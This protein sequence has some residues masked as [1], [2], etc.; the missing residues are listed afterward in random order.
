MTIWIVMKHYTGVVDEAHPDP[1]RYEP[2]FYFTGDTARAQALTLSQGL[3]RAMTTWHTLS[4]LAP[5]RQGP[6]HA[7]Q[8]ARAEAVVRAKDPDATSDSRYLV[9]PS[10]PYNGPSDDVTPVIIAM[11]TA[12]AALPNPPQDPFEAIFRLI[13]DAH[14]PDPPP[15]P[16]PPEPEP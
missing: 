2:K 1:R 15:E 13:R 6:D 4:N 10:D 9:E 14:V 12:F 3:N 16:P 8:L 7:Q 11:M 5:E